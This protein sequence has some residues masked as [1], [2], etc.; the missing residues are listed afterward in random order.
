MNN[1]IDKLNGNLSGFTTYNGEFAKEVNEVVSFY[2][3]YDGKPNNFKDIQPAT[4]YGQIWPIPETLDYMPTR[5][6]RNHAKKLIDK[7]GR[8]MFGVAPTLTMKPYDKSQKDMAEEKRTIVD[9]ILEQTNFWSHTSKA[10]LDATIGK[11]VLLCIDAQPGQPIQFRYYRM[12]EF[13]YTVDPNDYTKLTSVQICYQDESTSGKIVQDQV[14]HRWTYKMKG[15][16]CWYTYEQTDGVG[17][18]L[19]VERPLLDEN[20]FEIDGATEKI[21]V[22]QEINTNFSQIPCKVIL[23]GGLT[24]DISGT[25]DIKDLI[26]LA[27][28]YNRVNS[29]YR[30]ALRFKMFEQPVFID[31]DSSELSNIKIAPN[32]I[33]DLKT[34]PAIGDGTGTGRSAQATTLSSS[35][36]FST[37]ADSYLDRLK[38][39]MYELMDQPLPEQLASVPSAKALRFMFFDLIARCEQKW[40]DWEPAV[41][42]VVQMLEEA[43]DKCGL[44][45]ELNAATVLKTETNIVIQHNYPIPEDEEAKKD[46]AIK[47]VQANVMSRKTYI[48]KYSD[49]E[50]EQGEWNEIMEEIDELNNSSNTGFMSTLDEEEI[51]KDNNKGK[52]DESTEDENKDETDSENEDK[53]GTEQDGKQK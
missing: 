9:R 33:I 17:R 29:D 35:F 4:Q 30:D 53:K 8:F 15:E 26:D 10:F 37:A 34:D 1:F 51:S 7:Q 18:I 19:E 23:N 40:M 13:I 47:E 6:V 16:T 52:K 5:E 46:I 36:N 22:R 21:P 20:G 27:V 28:S 32:A 24:G 11:R 44:Y 48:R 3:F 2:E 45:P 39:D 25:S 42:W 50:D 14:W 31:A 41:K 38:K 49:V 43:C 12:S